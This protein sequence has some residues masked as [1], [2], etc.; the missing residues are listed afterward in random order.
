M[1]QISGETETADV[2]DKLGVEGVRA[3]GIRSLREFRTAYPTVR[4]VSTHGH[5]GLKFFELLTA[6]YENLQINPVASKEIFIECDERVRFRLILEFIWWLVRVGYVIPRTLTAS[7]IPTLLQ[8][9]DAGMRLADP[10]SDDDHP[11]LPGFLGRLQQRVPGIIDEVIAH[12]DDARSCLEHGLN[13]PAMVLIGLAYETAIEHLGDYL[14]SVSK[15]NQKTWDATWNA[16]KRINLIRQALP[17]CGMK[18]YD[19]S[20]VTLALDCADRIRVRRNDASHTVASYAFDHRE[21][22]DEY[23]VSACRHLPQLW[24]LASV[25]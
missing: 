13:R 24:I 18:P 17:T 10:K 7:G 20:Q 22:I 4:V 14:V 21:E 25:A 5:L 19:L 15:L 6:E 23:L 2:I 9:T 3:L 8:L 12:L 16:E 11:M 1:H